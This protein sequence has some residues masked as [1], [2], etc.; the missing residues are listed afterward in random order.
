MKRTIITLGAVGLIA[1]PAVQAAK[2]A[3]KNISINPNTATVKFGGTAV[4][5]GKLNGSNNGNRTITIEADESPYEGNF[6]NAGNVTTNSSGEWTFA[7]KPDQNTRYRARSGNADSKTV[8]V[9]VRPA[10]SLRVSDRTPAAG[11]RVRFSG[12]FCPQQDGSTVGLQRRVGTQWR[13]VRTVTLKDIAGSNCSSYSKRVRVRKD[14]SWRVH[15]N[16]NTNYV[17]GN[18]RTRRIDVH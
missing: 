5:S 15:W 8:D 1:V 2:P 10:I 14:S 13:T 11:R 4:L 12:R 3:P 7:A 16:G 6:S 9:N 17:A 18:S